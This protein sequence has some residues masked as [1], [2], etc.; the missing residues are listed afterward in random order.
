MFLYDSYA[1]YFIMNE[2]PQGVKYV[3]L[4]ARGEKAKSTDMIL[5]KVS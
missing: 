5:K 2:M 4:A 3:V 1:I